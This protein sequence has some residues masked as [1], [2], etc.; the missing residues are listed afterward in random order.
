LSVAEARVRSVEVL[1]VENHVSLLNVVVFDD[2]VV[3]VLLM[4][5]IGQTTRPLT[6]S[7]RM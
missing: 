4:Y 3:V 5:R 7:P 1:T 2:V 6:R